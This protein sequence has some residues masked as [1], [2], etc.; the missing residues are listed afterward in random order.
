MEVDLGE[1]G[2]KEV[3]RV[4]W[5]FCFCWTSGSAR[6]GCFT[7]Y[8]LGIGAARVEPAIYDPVYKYS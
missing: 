3:E 4:L 6:I 1:G 2:G 5:H 7:L 8:L